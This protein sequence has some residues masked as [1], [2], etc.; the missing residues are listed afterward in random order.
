MFVMDTDVLG[1]LLK[2]VDESNH[3]VVKVKSLYAVS[4]ESYTQKNKDCIFREKLF[5]LFLLFS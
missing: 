3:D 1:D 5:L 2:L 4:C